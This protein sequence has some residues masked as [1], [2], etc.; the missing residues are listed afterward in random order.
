M[1]A[2]KR[3]A[4]ILV[5]SLLV[6]G[7]SDARDYAQATAVLVDV[8]ATYV[9]QKPDVV[10]FVKMGILPDLLPGDSLLL[11]GIDDL[12]YEK[13]NVVADLK[14]D[15]RPSQANAQKQRFASE[16]DEFAASPE[17]AGYT[18]IPGAMMLAADY[19]KETG[20]RHQNIV[21]FSDLVEDLPNGASRRFDEREFEN[22]QV[23][24][25]NVKKLAVDNRDPARY[26]ERLA[27]WEKRVKDKGAS[28]WQVIL[29]PTTLVDVLNANRS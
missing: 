23:L 28:G 2:V 29:T 22:I 25:M 21:V 8:S 10:R 15:M 1:S 17:R 27:V 24:A 26:R 20:A 19:L 7:C 9:D 4:G 6:V 13:S 16:L 5:A 12:S 3:R 18:D 11:I 14:L